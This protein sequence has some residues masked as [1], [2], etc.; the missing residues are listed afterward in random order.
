MLKENSS[1]K[2]FGIGLSKTGL[3][4]L[5][6]AMTSLGYHSIRYPKYL[7]EIDDYDFAC[8]V[9]VATSFIELD[10]KYPGS[11]FILTSRDLDS[12]IMSLRKHVERYRSKHRS[13]RSNYW[14]LKTWGTTTFEEF[15]EETRRE[16]YSDHV[17]KVMDY[18]KDRPEDL[19]VIDI[20]GGEGWQ[21]LC[22]FLH[23]DIPEQAFPHENKAPN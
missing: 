3:H 17:K 21:K 11:K 7:E 8:D 23:K 13:E 14:R 18:F 9:S 1:S 15:D 16:T 19:L 12:W 6:K 2:I 4:S 22:S 5:T 10:K 20:C